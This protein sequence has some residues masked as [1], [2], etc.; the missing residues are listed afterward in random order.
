M[1]SAPYLAEIAF[2][3][4]ALVGSLEDS[5]DVLRARHYF[6]CTLKWKKLSM[7][8]MLYTSAVGV[9]IVIAMSAS[10][11]LFPSFLNLTQI[12]QSTSPSS[13]IGTGTAS[14]TRGAQAMSTGRCCCAFL[15]SAATS[16]S[17]LRST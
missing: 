16:S 5:Q 9:A 10:S 12:A 11:R 17:G 6:Y 1:L 13:Y 7:A 3:V 8:M 2:S 4:T 14:A 15:S